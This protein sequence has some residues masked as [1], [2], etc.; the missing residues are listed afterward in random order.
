MQNSVVSTAKRSFI[1]ILIIGTI[2]GSIIVRS[3][4]YLAKQF[5]SNCIINRRW[6]DKCQSFKF[7]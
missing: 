6:I 5:P 4:E 2:L 3:P 7:R 1:I